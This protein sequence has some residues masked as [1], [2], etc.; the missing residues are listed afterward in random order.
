MEVRIRHGDFKNLLE[1]RIRDRMIEV[2]KNNE[3]EIERRVEERLKLN[4]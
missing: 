1:S 4:N 3:I 2:S